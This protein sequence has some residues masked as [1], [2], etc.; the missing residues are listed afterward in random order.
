[1]LSLFLMPFIGRWELGHRFNVVWTFALLVGA[2]V[3]T[4]LAWYAR[5]QRHDARVAALPGRRREA[6]AEAERAVELAGSPT[7][8][9]PTGALALLASDPKT[10]GP[11]LFRQHCA[12]CHSHFD[13]G[14][15]DR[16]R[17]VPTRSSLEKP[18]AS[19]LWRFGSREWVA[20]ILDPEKVAGPHYF[21]NTAFKEGEMV[22]WV[23]DNIAPQLDRSCR[24]TS[25][26]SS[27]ARSRMSRSRSAA[28]ADMIARNGRRSGR[29][30]WPPAA[31]PSSTSL[32]ASIA[33]SSATTA[34][35]ASRPI[36]P[37]TPRASGSRRSSAIRSTSGSTR[38]RTIACRRSRRTQTNPTANRLTA[39][40]LALLVSWLRGEWYEPKSEASTV[41]GE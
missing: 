30:A 15:C 1:M 39:E 17:S 16:R 36:S 38:E 10:Q 12:A 35:W 3:L 33:T 21:G 6:D 34:T 32:P 2:G 11:K 41:G 20:G 5:P 26:P 31:R 24:A 22:T 8:I 25:W 40:E 19:N 4:A 9:P 13:P 29:A 27:A 7:G 28:E 37:A 23:N 14:R 18:T